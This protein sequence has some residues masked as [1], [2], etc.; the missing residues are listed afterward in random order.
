MNPEIPQLTQEAPADVSGSLLEE[1]LAARVNIEKVHDPKLRERL[2]QAQLAMEEVAIPLH[3]LHVMTHDDQ[4]EVLDKIV[5]SVFDADEKAQETIGLIKAARAKGDEE[6]IKRLTV[7]QKNRFTAMRRDVAAAIGVEIVDTEKENDDY[8]EKLLEQVR[9]M[10]DQPEE[11]IMRG[12]GF[13][14]KD[15]DGKER[16]NFPE[17]IFPPHIE[18]K[19]KSYESTIKAHVDAS[20][21]FNKAIADNSEEIVELD[22]FRRYAHNNLAKS[23]Q[24]FMK[25]EDWDFERVRKFIA[26]L[27]ERRFPTVETS[28]SKVTSGDVVSRLRTIQ[29]LGS[30]VANHETHN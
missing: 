28:E 4:L 19:W 27:V 5:D 25:L 10:G 30:A 16:F 1:V 26:K 21:R 14:V 6:S 9:G 15:E 22:A 17:N 29:A 24:E 2:E 12:L 11:D 8:R 18:E 7:E 23:V 3:D 13:L 20:S